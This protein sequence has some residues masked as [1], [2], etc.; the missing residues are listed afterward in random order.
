MRVF[1]TQLLEQTS[2]DLGSPLKWITIENLRSPFASVQGA[3][4]SHL[5]KKSNYIEMQI[6]LIDGQ[7]IAK[8]SWN[9]VFLQIYC[10][11]NQ[12]ASPIFLCRMAW[13]VLEGLNYYQFGIFQL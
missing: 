8:V 12:L 11:F 4:V 13:R 10:W 2:T 6:I 1:L 7:N 5:W 3:L 9:P